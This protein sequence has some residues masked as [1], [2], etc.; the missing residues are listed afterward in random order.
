MSVPGV[1]GRAPALQ[2]RLNRARALA[3]PVRGMAPEAV[4]AELATRPLLGVCEDKK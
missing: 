2:Q 3:G 4:T 1:T